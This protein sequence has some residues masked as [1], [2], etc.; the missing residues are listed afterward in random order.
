MTQFRISVVL[1]CLAAPQ[2]LPF[3]W[4]LTIGDSPMFN[5]SGMSFFHFFDVLMQLLIA[6]SFT[7]RQIISADFSRVTFYSDSALAIFPLFSVWISVQVA[8][9]AEPDVCQK[10]TESRPG[11]LRLL[12]KSCRPTYR[13]SGRFRNCSRLIVPAVFWR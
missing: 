2:C 9:R 12:L 3:Q 10:T 5:G 8:F 6:R 7:P 1:V 11:L 4:L 13:Y